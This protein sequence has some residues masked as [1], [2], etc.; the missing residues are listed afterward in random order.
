MKN[1]EQNKKKINFSVNKVLLLWQKLGIWSH[2]IHCLLLYPMERYFPWSKVYIS[3]LY[4]ILYC[5]ICLLYVLFLCFRLSLLFHCHL[6]FLSLSL[7]TICSFY[8]SE[9][10]DFLICLIAMSSICFSF[11]LLFLFWFV[12]LFILWC[13]PFIFLSFSVILSSQCLCSPFLPPSSFHFIFLSS[14]LLPFF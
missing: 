11:F 9:C 13:L 2:S 5:I 14:R 1:I 3:D 8:V 6:F 10:Q 12:C 4:Y 7:F